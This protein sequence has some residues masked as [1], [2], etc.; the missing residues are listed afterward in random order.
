MSTFRETILAGQADPQKESPGTWTYP[1]S[2][3]LVIVPFPRS[4]DAESSLH[5][6]VD[7]VSSIAPL[8]QASVSQLPLEGVVLPI[9]WVESMLLLAFELVL[10]PLYRS[11]DGLQHGIEDGIVGSHQTVECF[12]LVMA[13]RIGL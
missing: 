13:E 12:P 6:G 9:L 1:F 10:L 7:P 3:T 8:F 11:P 4:H 5:G 2:L